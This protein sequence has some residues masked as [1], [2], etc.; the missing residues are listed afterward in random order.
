MMNLPFKTYITYLFI[1]IS[2]FLFSDVNDEHLL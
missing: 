2:L 1:E